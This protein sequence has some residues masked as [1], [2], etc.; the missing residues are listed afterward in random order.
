MQ[1]AELLAKSRDDLLLG[2]QRYR[3]KALGTLGSLATHQLRYILDRWLRRTQ[4]MYMA[5]PT[6][7]LA[8][9]GIEWAKWT[10]CVERCL[11]DLAA[12]FA[13]RHHQRLMYPRS[14]SATSERLFRRKMASVGR[15][16]KRRRPVTCN[17]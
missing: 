16:D 4:E 13:R 11:K 8:Y 7:F 12:S 2:C 3:T 14:S 9:L 15:G 5:P 17:V 1:R 10:D 6:Q